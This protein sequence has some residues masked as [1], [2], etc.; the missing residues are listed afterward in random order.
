MAIVWEQHEID[1]GKRY[2]GAE[3][4]FYL[5]LGCRTGAD[6]GGPHTCH[7]AGQ[8]ICA[9]HEHNWVRL[10]DTRPVRCAAI[11]GADEWGSLRCDQRA[12]GRW[13][14][15]VDP[16]YINDLCGY[17]GHNRGES[18]GPA[19][20]EPKRERLCACPDYTVIGPSGPL[21]RY[22]TEDALRP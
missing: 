1:Q 17:H 9:C 5:S 2:V 18:L 3:R 15:R 14:N 6:T 16:S 8:C 19:A 21:C 12:I 4:P 13:P 20:R 10:E 22:C 7:E 11:Y